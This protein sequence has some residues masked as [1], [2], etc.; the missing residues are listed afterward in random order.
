MNLFICAM[1]GAQL[2]SNLPMALSAFLGNMSQFHALILSHALSLQR[3]K[4]MTQANVEILKPLPLKEGGGIG[5]FTPS[6]PANVV[7]ESKYELGLKHL[8]SL[9]FQTIE[10]SLTRRKLTEGYRSASPKARAE[11]MME[12]LED[13]RVQCLMATIGGSNSSSMIPYLDF[14]KIRKSQKIICGYSDI[15]SLHMA[16]LRYS[17]L[18]TLYGPTLVPIFGEDPMPFYAIDSFLSAVSGNTSY[19]QTLVPPKEYSDQFVDATLSD[20]KSIRREWKI[21]EGWRVLSPGEIM[22]EVIVGDLETLL[23]SA[24]TP[25]FPDLEGKLLMIEE[26]DAPF[27]KEERNFRHLELLGVFDKI[28]GLIISKPFSKNSQGASFSYEELMMEVIQKRNYPIVSNFDAGHTL[29]MI[30]IAQMQRVMLIA[31]PSGHVT[32]TFLDSATEVN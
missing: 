18:S 11:E 23:T 21:N 12:L 14:A 30:S 20:W 5:I 2:W 24:G 29:P 16:V 19:P 26:M 4:N 9:G 3:E 22:A 25:H 1:L 10:G 15:T 27:S 7:L 6:W 8:R 28:A 31:E 13:S 32:F 17:G